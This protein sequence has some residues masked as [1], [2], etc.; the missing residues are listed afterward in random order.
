M[1][2]IL[3]LEEKQ[4]ALH[5]TVEFLNSWKSHSK[6]KSLVNIFLHLLAQGQMTDA[7]RVFDKIRQK[8]EFSKWRRGYINA[9]E[10]MIV[11]SVA[12]TGKNAF[13]NQIQAERI[14]KLRK[15]FLKQS[16]NVLH[17]DFDKGF[18]AAWADY[19]RVLKKLN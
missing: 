7:K 19:I 16:R 12:R 11:A 5:K 4:K 3:E 2:T 9:L 17:D 8:I 14:A 6:R 1:T 10:G 18:F 15:I 13:I